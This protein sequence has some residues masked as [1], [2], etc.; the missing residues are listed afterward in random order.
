MDSNAGTISPPP[1][2]VTFSL[3]S[4]PSVMSLP[5]SS[6]PVPRPGKFFG[7]VV[8]MRHSITP[9]LMAGVGNAA[10]APATTP[11]VAPPTN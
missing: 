8:T 5:S 6:A 11:V 3:P 7:Q 1:Y 2:T 10:A 9:W 4:E